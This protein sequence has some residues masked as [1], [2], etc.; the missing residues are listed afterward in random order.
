M[1]TS[2]VAT[3]L[4]LRKKAAARSAIMTVGVAVWPPGM[5]G[6]VEESATRTPLTPITLRSGVTTASF[7]VPILQVPVSALAV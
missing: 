7:P 2:V 4:G 6:M 3:S 1:M 5:M